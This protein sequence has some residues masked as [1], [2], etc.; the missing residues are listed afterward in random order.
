M[1]VN[2]IKTHF[3][4]DMKFDLIGHIKSHKALLCLKLALFLNYLF[5]VKF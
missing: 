4:H 5:E 1:N 3:F 2:L